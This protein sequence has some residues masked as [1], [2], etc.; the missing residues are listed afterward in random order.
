MRTFAWLAGLIVVGIVV[1]L[2][3]LYFWGEY[4]GDNEVRRLEAQ[5]AHL[6][7]QAAAVSAAA[8]LERATGE[9]ALKASQGAAIRAPAAAAARVVDSQRRV[10]ALYGYLTPALVVVVVALAALGGGA[11]GCLLVL[12][13]VDWQRKKAATQPPTRERL[14][15]PAELW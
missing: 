5:A 10:V 9:A 11:I 8:D 1:A 7:A 13:F 2:V 15:I 4:T 14:S 6:R 3:G 12:A